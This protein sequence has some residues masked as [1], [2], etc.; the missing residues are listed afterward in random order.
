MDL[1]LESNRTSVIL[2]S[3]AKAEVVKRRDAI[4]VIKNFIVRLPLRKYL[5]IIVLY[6]NG[7]ENL[8]L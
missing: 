7:I 8:D 2:S 5:K 1:E 3:L 6:Q 4:T